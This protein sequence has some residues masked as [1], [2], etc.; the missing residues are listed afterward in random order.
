MNL[1]QLQEAWEIDCVIDDNHLDRESVRTPNLHA[2]YLNF[3]IG[4]K[5]KLAKAKKD[6][7]TLRQLKFRYYRG[8]LSQSELATNGWEQWQGVK[9]LKNEMEEFLEGDIDL[10]EALLK[11][12]YLECIINYLESVMNQIKSRDWA[13]RNSIEWKKFISGA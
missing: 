5:L 13:I 6:Y 3:L 1:E 7:N 8:E 4:Y 12:E 11:Q 9:P 2:K 10:S